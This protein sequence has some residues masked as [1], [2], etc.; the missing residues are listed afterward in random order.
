MA[1]ATVVSSKIVAPVG[2]A[3]VGG[4]DDR[5]VFVAAAD[6]L[7]E[8]AGG[9][10]GHRQVAELVDDQQLRAVPE[11]HRVGPAAFER[12]AWRCGRRG[13][14]RWCSRRGSRPRRRCGR[15]IVASIVLPTPGGPISKTLAFSSMKRSVARS[16]TRRRSRRGLGAEV[17]LL[18]RLAG[19][20]LGEAQPALEAALLDGGDLGGEQVVQE[21]GVA[22]LV[23]LG[24]LERGRELLGD[25]G[26]AQVGEVRAELLV[27]GV[28][29]QHATSASCGVAAPDRSTGAG[30]PVRP[31]QARELGERVPGR[32]AGWPCAGRRG[33]W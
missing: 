5:A 32:A 15:A 22:G 31:L 28:G 11:A 33:R 12:G 29:H 21:L 27:G 7:E 17:E 23:A 3:A 26:E 2:D 20:K 25:G 8:V 4:Q 24:V 9:F 18:E 19:G 6:D 10:V 16:S 14:R 13:R 30:S 1:A